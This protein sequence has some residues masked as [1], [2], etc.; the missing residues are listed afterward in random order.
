MFVRD[1][2]VGYRKTACRAWPPR[3]SHANAMLTRRLHSLFMDWT[4]GRRTPGL[5]CFGAFAK[6]LSWAYRL[7]AAAD[8]WL[9]KPKVSTVP[10]GMRLIVISS[11]V[12]GGVGKTPLVAHLA[13]SLLQ[14]GHK[15]HVVTTGYRRSG[16]GDVTVDSSSEAANAL[17]AGDEALMIWKATGAPVHVGGR[18][19]DV[20]KSVGHESSP[21]FI[22]LD[23]GVRQRWH[24]ERRIVVLTPE[25]LE[26]P[27]RFLPDGRWRISPRRAWPASGVAVIQVGRAASSTPAEGTDDRHE[28]ILRAWGYRGPVGWY[29]SL[30]DGIV[31]LSSGSSEPTDSPLDDNP[32]VFCGVG[33]PSRFVRQVELLGMKAAGM[34]RFP[35]HHAYSAADW[36]E[37]EHRCRQAGAGWMLTTHKDAVKIDRD[38]TLTIP[39]Y[40]LRIRLEL[41][42]G[43]DML[44]VVLEKSE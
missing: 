39:V 37:L 16:N 6:P 32:F 34:Q 43:V 28:T 27:V 17:Q 42:A 9:R 14:R 5:I 24:G 15:T 31:R 21:D 25:D 29:A 44:S 36:A 30:A 41:V 3:Y 22:V 1:L 18:L 12:V 7:G 13:A 10:D 33:S 2:V 4:D 8:G 20:V 19:A 11:P 40:W 35:D 38:W 26:R 23:N